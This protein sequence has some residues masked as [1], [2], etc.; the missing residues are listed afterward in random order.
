MTGVHAKLKQKIQ[1]VGLNH[2]PCVDQQVAGVRKT[3]TENYWVDADFIGFEA[4]ALQILHGH[5][6][7]SVKFYLPNLSVFHWEQ[8]PQDKR[9]NRD[10]DGEG[11]A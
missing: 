8:L 4:G 11:C 9:L 3:W 2:R 1:E 7:R 5:F 6:S 10:L